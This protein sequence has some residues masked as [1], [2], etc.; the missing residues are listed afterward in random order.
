MKALR[1]RKSRPDHHENNNN[2]N[3]NKCFEGLF[4]SVGGPN[5][6]SRYNSR[7]R[8]RLYFDND[9]SSHLLEGG[10]R[11]QRS[12][13]GHG[14]G[15]GELLNFS[16][17]EAI[18]GSDESPFPPFGRS[19]QGVSQEEEMLCEDRGRRR[20]R[21]DGRRERRGRL[22]GVEEEFSADGRVEGRGVRRKK[23]SK[24]YPLP[25]QQ[26]RE[27]RKSGRGKRERGVGGNEKHWMGD[28][29]MTGSREREQLNMLL[30]NFEWLN[31]V[32][33]TVYFLALRRESGFG[34]MV[35]INPEMTPPPV[36]LQ[37][38]SARLSRPLFQK[39]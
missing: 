32:R 9:F 4:T 2:N 23:E 16:L 28:G 22:Y 8:E 13:G 12:L 20:R 39:E 25:L 36:R 33:T 11:G 29:S 24:A 5:I 10:V 7:S 19:F 18:S 34:L 14:G 27:P 1:R 26:R 15:H 38:F 21:V 35:K 6:L 31:K 17:P 3:H 30:P 37:V